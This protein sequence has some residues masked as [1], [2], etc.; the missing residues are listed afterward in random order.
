MAYDVLI[1]NARICD[2]TGAAAFSG[3]V[4]VREGKIVEVGNVSG[5]A[6]REINADGL[7]LAPGFVDHHTHYDAQIS[8]DPLLTSS[9]WHGITSV[10]MGNCGVGVAPCRAAERGI[11]AWDLVNVEAMPY[12]VL[13]NGV[14]WAWESFP[15][16]LAAISKRPL[17][18]NAGFLV[19]LSALRFFVL[20]EEAS[21]RAARSEEIGKMTDLLRQA[22]KAGAFGFSLSL[23]RQHIGYHGRPLS[24]RLASREELAALASVLREVGYGVIELALTRTAGALAEDE[25]ELLTLLAERSGRPITWLAL[26]DRTDMPYVYREALRTV[27]PYIEGG[28]RIHPQVT[29]RPARAYHNLRTPFLFASYASWKDAFNRSP[30]EQL[31]L[32]TTPEFREAFRQE[33]KGKGGVVFTGQWDR[34]SVVKVTR[35]EHQRWLNQSIAE[36]AAQTG[37]DPVDALLDLVVAENLEAGFLFAATNTNPDAVQELIT[38][39]HVLIGLS[40]AGAHV[41]Q[42]CNAGVPTYLLHEWVHKRNVMS[43]EEGV[44]R[45]TS[46]P[47]N[48]LGLKKKGRI[49]QGMDADLVLFDLDTVKPCPLEWV[50][51]LPGGKP[52][53]IER[54][55]GVAYTLVNG[56]IFFAHG[57][58]QGGY[59]GRVMRSFAA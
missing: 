53:L 5:A 29:P 12:E 36:V 38:N 20:G 13:L 25:L 33:L 51:D 46:E 37:K 41:D 18:M 2:G 43:V 47:A 14:S 35:P 8:W 19:P 22:M 58:H 39:P 1:K 48:F 31:A 49:A 17:G 44:R 57:E 45:L 32:Y 34:V 59:A 9:C 21:E 6:R 15:E 42:S 4:A 28:M 40:D 23:L 3:A 55:E 24:S 27:A 30:E 54:A 7:I 10:V 50:N 16:Y 56:E 26:V 52:R 11:V